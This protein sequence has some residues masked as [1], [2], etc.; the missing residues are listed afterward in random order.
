[1]NI[2]FHFYFFDNLIK[3]RRKKLKKKEKKKERKTKSYKI[4]C[5]LILIDFIFQFELM[6]LYLK[7]Y[8]IG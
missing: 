2:K 3:T 5:K 4:F 1:M 8:N 6:P 7:A